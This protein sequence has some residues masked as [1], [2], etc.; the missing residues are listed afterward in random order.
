MDGWLIPTFVFVLHSHVTHCLIASDSPVSSYI[1]VFRLLATGYNKVSWPFS[2]ITPLRFTPFFPS[3]DVRVVFK[4]KPLGCPAG[5]RIIA[6]RSY[7]S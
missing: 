4:A 1:H 3:N 6:F 2:F 7:S 5:T